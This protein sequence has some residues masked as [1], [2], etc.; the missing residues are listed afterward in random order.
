MKTLAALALLILGCH[1]TPKEVQVPVTAVLQVVEP[2]PA[3][4]KIVLPSPAQINRDLRPEAIRFSRQYGAPFK[5]MTIHR[6]EVDEFEHDECNVYVTFDIGRDK[7]LF[8]LVY[9]R[10][11]DFWKLKE[12]QS[13]YL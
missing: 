8:V 10:R 7:G 4:K 6:R 12:I 2:A 3:P 11:G 13:R 5:N 1:Q 9:S